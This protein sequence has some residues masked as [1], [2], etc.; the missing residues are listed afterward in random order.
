MCSNILKKGSFILLLILFQL[1]KLDL[2]L[3]ET[4]DQENIF[5]RGFINYLKGDFSNAIQVWEP[6]AQEGHSSAQY[7]LGILFKNGMGVKVNL[8]KAGFWFRESARQGDPGA[9]YFLADFLYAGKGMPQNKTLAAFWYM[10]SAEQDYPDSQFMIGKMYA[11]GIGIQKDLVS[12][13]IWLSLSNFNGIEGSKGYLKTITE[14]LPE[15]DL[16]KARMQIRNRLS[17]FSGG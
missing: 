15:D 11:S 17:R 13:Y 4:I 2:V 7:F 1:T 6:I 12:A 10:M 5:H 14:H 16:I 9:Q 3:A 8:E